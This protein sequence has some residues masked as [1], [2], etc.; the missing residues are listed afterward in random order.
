MTNFPNVPV[1]GLFFD[2]TLD[3]SHPVIAQALVDFT[4]A[5]VLAIFVNTMEMIGLDYDNCYELNAGG[6]WAT[7]YPAKEFANV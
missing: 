6:S 4:Q 3:F 7:A 2:V 1:N 5:E